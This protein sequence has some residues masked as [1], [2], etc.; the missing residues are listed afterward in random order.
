MAN[1]I[2]RTTYDFA[3][4]LIYAV[5]LDALQ[6]RSDWFNDRWNGSVYRLNWNLSR[7]L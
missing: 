6:H 3:V 1:Y 4:M 5:M 7:N 2:Y